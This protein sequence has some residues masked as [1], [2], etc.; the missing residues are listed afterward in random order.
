M[1]PRV[2]ASRSLAIGL[3]LALAGCGETGPTGPVVTLAP[4]AAPSTAA[5][6]G[7][8]TGGPTAVPSPEV[9]PEPTE[10]TGPSASPGETMLVRAYFVLGSFTGNEGI[11]P[12]LRSVPRSP[13]AEI[14]AMEGL[15]A[16]PI[17]KE[18][19]ARPALSTSIPAGTRLNGVTIENG[20][21]TVDLSGEFASGG[22]SASMFSRLA[23]VVYT[24]TQFTSVQAV[25]F[26]LDG[27]PVTTFSS[28]GIDLSKP[29]ARG[30][31][32]DQLPEIWMDRP[33]WGAGFGNPGR[34]A[35]LTDVFEATFRVSVI[36]GSSKVLAD[37]Q[38]MASCGTGC[39]GKFDVTIPYAVA[40]AGW[41]TVRVY[42]L[43]AKDGTPENVVDYPV[44]LTPAG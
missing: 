32:T 40:K 15:L 6:S 8:P 25:R 31:Y 39:W 2:I 10:P 33:A 3:I 43:S 27:V 30:D 16:G 34:V 24:L 7:T 23:Q 19:S 35:G 22:G 1:H 12:V 26:E 9:T 5:A 21:A 41:G 11:V 17:Q 18:L 28:E 44:W 4:S 13:N 37:E 42:D 36:D 38:V 20:L 14:P 29:V